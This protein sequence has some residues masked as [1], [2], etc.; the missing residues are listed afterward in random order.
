MGEV[1]Q[2]LG[3]DAAPRAISILGQGQKPVA[4]QKRAGFGR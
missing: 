1:E 4:D 2:V 3:G